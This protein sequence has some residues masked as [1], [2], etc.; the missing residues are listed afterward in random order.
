MSD[1]LDT[2]EI[3]R[4]GDLQFDDRWHP[5]HGDDLKVMRGLRASFRLANR[6]GRLI[7]EVLSALPS[8]PAAERTLTVRVNGRKVGTATLKDAGLHRLVFE[9]R[10]LEG[11]AIDVELEVDRLVRPD[12]SQTPGVDSGDGYGLA[13]RS[14]KVT[15]RPSDTTTLCMEPWT[16]VFIT[17]DGKVRTCCFSQTDMGHLD[18]QTIDEIWQGRA[19]AEIR[20]ALG[21][22]E[23]P[24]DCAECVENKRMKFELF[25]TADSLGMFPR[26][27]KKGEYPKYP[28]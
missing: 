20:E 14:A 4:T 3:G 28:P 16:T 2:L 8:M 17:W 15:T 1:L 11:A 25:P 26:R 6:G 24:G 7:L 18:E 12:P 19:Y 9:F 21:T 27:N 5:V 22:R 13:V 10:P 23:V